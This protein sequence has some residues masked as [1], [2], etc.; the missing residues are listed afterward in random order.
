MGKIHAHLPLSSKMNVHTPSKSTCA[1][2]LITLGKSSGVERKTRAPRGHLET[3]CVS[4]RDFPGLAPDC[5]SDTEQEHRRRAI[6]DVNTKLAYEMTDWLTV[7]P[8]NTLLISFLKALEQIAH[9]N[10]ASDL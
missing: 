10:L 2:F 4:P 6:K 7:Y 8:R 1:A 9:R 5:Q 3:S